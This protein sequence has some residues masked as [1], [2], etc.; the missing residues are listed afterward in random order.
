MK[1][2]NDNVKDWIEKRTE[3]QIK[4]LEKASKIFDENDV[5]TVNTLEAIYG[6]ETSFG[7]KKFLG[8][9]GSD[10]AAGHFQ[11]KKET[12]IENGLK[13]TAKNDERFDV[14]LASVSVAKQLKKLDNLFLGKVDLGNKVFAIAIKDNEE[15][16]NFAVIAYNAGQGRMVKAQ[17][18]AKKADKDATKLEDVKNYLKEAGANQTQEKEALKYIELILEYEQEFSKKSKANKKI[19]DKKPGKDSASIED[20]HWITND[21]GIHV[22]IENKRKVWGASAGRIL[23]IRP[24]VHFISYKKQWT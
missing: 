3:H 14:D 12:A 19:K 20:G 16:K 24:W 5:L 15:R 4:A 18:A 8:I 23:Q 11:Q 10:K 22:F 17:Y 7:N 21:A 9:K 6:R 1:N 2:N 13:V